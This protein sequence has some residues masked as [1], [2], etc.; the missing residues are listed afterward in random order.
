MRIASF[1][2]NN[3]FDRAKAMNLRSWEKGKPIVAAQA[4]V[5]TLFQEE[6]YT[7]AIK[8]RILELLEI[9]GLQRRDD[10][11]FASLRKISGHL[12]YRPR[13]GPVQVAASG[14]ADWIGWVELGTEPVN[15][16]ARQHTA[17]VIRDVNA[18]VL[19]V[20][21]AEDRPSLKA[22]SE[23]LL[24]AVGGVPY[25]YVMLVEGSDSRG[26]DVGILTRAGYS[27]GPIRT[28]V[29]DADAEGVI[30]SRDCCEYH[31]ATPGGAELVVLVNHLKSKGYSS[32]G[33][34]LG[35]NRRQRQAC[36]VAEIYDNLRAGGTDLIAVLGDLNDYPGAD[37]LKPLI[38]GTDL[39]DIS[40]HAQ[41]DFGP[42]KGTFNG[43]NE[44]DKIDYVLLSPALYAHATGGGVFRK[45]VWHGPKV[46]DPWPMYETLTADVHAASDHAAIYADI[47]L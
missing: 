41:F 25:E 11:E 47:D 40:T 13:V 10:S 24:P 3:L 34:P 46:H 39:R 19:G 17:M 32:P 35:A 28:H 8:A 44:A 12:L 5:N 9:L 2:V 22:F 18:D 7:E 37:A 36:R 23:A 31:L 1:N 4:E 14:R 42:R 21:E 26:I 15:E 43:G 30:F 45:G 27:L 16:L 33:D 29:Y 20:T 6:V 38:A